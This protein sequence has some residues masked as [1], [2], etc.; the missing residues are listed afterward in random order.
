[1]RDPVQPIN[2]D[3]EL[4]PAYQRIHVDERPR[5]PGVREAPAFEYYGLRVRV[6]TAD[7]LRYGMA[8]A[9]ADKQ[10]RRRAEFRAVVEKHFS[11]YEVAE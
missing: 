4:G 8:V 7:P 3:E 5:P 11:G 1:M 6:I 2:F 9:E 10:S